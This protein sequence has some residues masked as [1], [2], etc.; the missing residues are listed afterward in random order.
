MSTNTP[1]IIRR[2]DRGLTISGTR[3]TL[4]ALMEYLRDGW[5]HEDIRSW[6]ALT[7]AQ[8]R[9]ALDYIAAHRAEVEAEYDEV[10]RAAEEQ[11]HY[12]EERLREHLA[13]HPPAP[14]TPEKAVLYAKLAEQRAQT[15][16]ELAWGD[17]PDDAQDDIEEQMKA[18]HP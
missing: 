7:E 18:I 6:L 4:Y 14:P 12:W 3:V 11:R 16:R 1:T 17:A 15:L 5:A 2:P 13:H 9:A 8:L 10:V